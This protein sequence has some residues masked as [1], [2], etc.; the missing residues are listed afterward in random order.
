M[1]LFYRL[2]ALAC[3]G[4][5]SLVSLPLLA[6]DPPAPPSPFNDAQ[7]AG[8]ETVVHDYLLKHPE[9]ILQAVEAYQAN[10]QA[11]KDKAA[12]DELTKRQADLLHDPATQVL[13]NASSDCAIIEF[14]DNQCP[15]CQAN[16]PEIQKLLKD[17]NKIKLVLKEFPI[18]G[19]ISLVASKAALASVKQG[20]YPQFHEALLAHKGHYDKAALVDEI[21]KSVG[22]NLDLLHK[23]MDSPEIQAEIDKTLEL[24]RALDINGTPGFVIGDQI[25]SGASSVDELKKYVADACKDKG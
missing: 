4:V 12:K 21:A 25:I 5:A 24:G 19:P 8:I 15:Y 22:L 6:A 11:D 3:I 18:L 23:D 13:G 2:S 14:F 9:I 7:K 10:L 17:D 20:K 16:E 1:R